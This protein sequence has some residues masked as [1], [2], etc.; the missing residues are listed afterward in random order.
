MKDFGCV[1]SFSFES[2]GRRRHK[3][4]ANMSRA[5]TSSSVVRLFLAGDFMPGRGIDAVMPRPCPL[6]IREGFCTSS[7]EY[8]RLAERKHK[9]RFPENQTLSARDVLD[10]A[11]KLIERYEPHVKLINLETSVTKKSTFYPNKGINYR[12]SE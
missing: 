1:F 11:S 2:F 3:K 6:E 4:Y 7:I 9:K 12:A 10:E 5:F 8:A